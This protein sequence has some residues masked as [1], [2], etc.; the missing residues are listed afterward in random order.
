[1]NGQ[2]LLAVVLRGCTNLKIDPARSLP[3]NGGCQ[4]SGDILLARSIELRF[5]GEQIRPTLW[6]M[7]S[8]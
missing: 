5:G 6:L 8:A 4:E 7:Y 2:I 3:V 1:M